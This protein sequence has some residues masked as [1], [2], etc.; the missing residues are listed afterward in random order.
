MADQYVERGIPFLRSQNISPFR[1]DD[2]NL[3]FIN[4][5][6][7]KKLKKSA[8]SPGDV[9]VVRTGYPG[10]ACVLPRRMTIANCADLVIIRPSEEIDSYYLCCLFNSV[11]GRGK[12]AGSL[13]GVAQQH[14]NIGVAKEMEISL[15]PISTQKRAVN[16]LS[17]YNDLIENNTRRITILEEMTKMIYR[18]WFVNFRF[19][20]HE[21]VRMVESEMGP[22][23]AGWT[24]EPLRELTTLINRGISPQYDDDAKGLVVNQKCIRDGRLSLDPARKQSKKV[25]EGKLIRLGDVLINSTGVGTLGRVAQV[26]EPVSNCTVDSHVSIVRPKNNCEFL[27]KALLQLEQHF[28]RLGIGSTGQTELSRERIGSTKLIV[29]TPDLQERFSAAVAPMNGMIVCCLARNSNLCQTRDLLLPKLISGEVN[30]EQSEAET[31]A[32]SV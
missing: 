32:Q 25:P 14:F 16:V 5:D 22:I 9:L 12:V 11:W 18:E 29:P 1:L 7:H 26:L 13:V 20:G 30:V 23:P 10:T 8:I 28:E 19:P 24:V 2:S 17:A 6:F 3:K 15:P 31:V 21:K 4:E 27:G